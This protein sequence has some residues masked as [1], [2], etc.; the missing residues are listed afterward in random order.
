MQYVLLAMLTY[1]AAVLDAVWSSAA[2]PD[3]LLLV[4]LGWVFARPGWQGILGAALVGLA[5]DLNSAARPGTH[6]AVLA[7]T[8]FALDRWRGPLGLRQPLVQVVLSWPL[9]MLVAF[10]AGAGS[11]IAGGVSEYAAEFSGHVWQVGWQTAAVAAVILPLRP[12]LAGFGRRR[13]AIV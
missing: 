11:L 5:A 8:A 13:L 9:A 12:M 6:V 1:L 10:C 4:A 3:W 7:L 2:G